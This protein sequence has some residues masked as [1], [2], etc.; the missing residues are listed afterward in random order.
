MSL[1]S[2]PISG[3]R[4]KNLNRHT[5]G[6]KHTSDDYRNQNATFLVNG[7]SETKYAFNGTFA[8]FDI[9]LS[10]VSPN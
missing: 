8:R 1:Q 6:L 7:S 2:T 4:L 3:I 9:H 5:V 10:P